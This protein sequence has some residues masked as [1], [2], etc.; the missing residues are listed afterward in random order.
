MIGVFVHKID[1]VVGLC[2]YDE[3]YKIKSH[4]YIPEFLSES[5]LCIPL[6]IFTF[7]N[8]ITSFLASAAP[9]QVVKVT[10]T[11]R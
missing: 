5:V 6:T 1:T 3:R 4:V 7:V 9:L 2:M 11:Q 10:E 8:C